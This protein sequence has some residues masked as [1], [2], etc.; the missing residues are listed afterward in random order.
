LVEAV[1]R[2]TG[3][4]IML[5]EVD[6]HIGRKLIKLALARWIA[7]QTFT[8]TPVA[9]VSEQEQPAVEVAGENFGGRKAGAY[10]PLGN[11][12]ERANVFMLWGRVHQDCRSIA[13]HDPEVAPK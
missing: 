5:V 8:K 6:E 12:D 2:E 4:G 13:V 11:G 10:K 3:H 9:E 1:R 7:V